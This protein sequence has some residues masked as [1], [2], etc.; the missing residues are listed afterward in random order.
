MRMRRSQRYLLMSVV[1]FLIL[2]MV[3]V[4]GLVKTSQ[5]SGLHRAMI[6]V[7][8]VGVAGTLVSL[9]LLEIA[10][11]PFCSTRSVWRRGH[12]CMVS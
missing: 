11:K 10:R 6:H 2:Y 7:I 1:F 12:F 5:H 8:Q 3:G 9:V 4:V